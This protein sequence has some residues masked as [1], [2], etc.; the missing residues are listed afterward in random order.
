MGQECGGR[1]FAFFQNGEFDK[2]EQLLHIALKM[3]QDMGHFDGTTYIF[4]QLA[5]V[6]F[7]RV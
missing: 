4:N 3:S 5:N 2:A 6:A 7:E 1:S